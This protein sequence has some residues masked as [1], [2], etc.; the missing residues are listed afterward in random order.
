[1]SQS[2]RPDLAGSANFRYIVLFMV[3]ADFEKANMYSQHVASLSEQAYKALIG[4][5]AMSMQ[6]ANF[7]LH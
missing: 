2:S 7:V 6:K 1:M 5:G 3:M 4:L